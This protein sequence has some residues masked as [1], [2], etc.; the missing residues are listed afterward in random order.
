M[1]FVR[2]SPRPMESEITLWNL[3]VLG[4]SPLMQALNNSIRSSQNLDF[5]NKVAMVA[6]SQDFKGNLL[7]H[8]K[9]E[10]LVKKETVHVKD[11]FASMT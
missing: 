7:K 3:D 10:N 1:P 6:V 5:K 4:Q 11:S 2:Q 8:K 9:F